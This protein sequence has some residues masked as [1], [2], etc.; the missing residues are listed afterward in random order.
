MAQKVTLGGDRLGAGQKQKVT[1]R[2]YE[3]ST[4][5]LGF[6]WKSSMATGVLT[7]FMS[8]VGLNGD[9][10]QIKLDADCLTLP[11]V[12][13][14]F[15]RFK[16]Q[17]DVFTI[18]IR[19]Y[20]AQLHNNKLGI[21][22]NMAAIK[23]PHITMTAIPNEV[24]KVPQPLNPSSIHNYLGIAGLGTTPLAPSAIY[25]VTFNAIPYLAYYDIFKNYYAN[26]QEENAYVIHHEATLA[27]SE[28]ATLQ[29]AQNLDIASVGRE[30]VTVI[31]VGDLPNVTGF[32]LIKGGGIVLRTLET[33]GSAAPTLDDY[34]IKWGNS[35]IP[36]E[37][38]QSG[39]SLL[40]EIFQ[41][42]SQFKR[43]GVIYNNCEVKPSWIGMY[44]GTTVLF[45]QNYNFS[46]R[47][48]YLQAFKLKDIDDMR[49]DILS[50]IKETTS[51]G[52]SDEYVNAEG[53][54]SVYALSLEQDPT[55]QIRSAS[56]PLEGLCV[57][58]YR[59]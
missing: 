19:L 31:E 1:L 27:T 17:L 20:Q 13:P 49:E 44:V 59:S 57:K 15:G 46:D 4:H 24:V 52:I 51:F 36:G 58:S 2:G 37:N 35:N 41:L 47:E 9:S 21:G 18:P 26:K 38:T 12:G 25:Q 39:D 6:N 30:D 11:T 42:Q 8:I 56:F 23:L 45:A 14:L 53:E 28:N 5:D 54:K 10:F 7:P 16:V 3:R 55:T 40:S 33:A 29:L 48:P 22:M 34:T 43:D 32:P 50:K